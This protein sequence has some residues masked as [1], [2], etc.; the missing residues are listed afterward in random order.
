MKDKKQYLKEYYLKNRER[1]LVLHK[2]YRDTHKDD[3]KKY[4][5]ENKEA[6]K[7][8]SAEY[9]LKNKEKRNTK[10]HEWRKENKDWMKEYDKQYREGNKD[11][12]KLM[13]QEWRKKNKHYYK[14]NYWKCPEKRIA[15]VKKY[16]KAHPDMVRERA[17]RYRNNNPEMVKK[18]NQRIQERLPD[19]YIIRIHPQVKGY[20]QLINLIR[21][22][23]LIKRELKEIS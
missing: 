6:L 19:F 4:R 14:Q 1:L 9:N 12:I 11:K 5:D 16:R 22:N 13:Q 3:M 21:T 23:I 7:K 18:K 17:R 2:E 15:S 8:Y 20:P 10:I